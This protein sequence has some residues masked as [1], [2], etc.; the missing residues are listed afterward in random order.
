[1][2]K[3]PETVRQQTNRFVSVSDATLNACVQF[4]QEYPGIVPEHQ[5]IEKLMTLDFIYPLLDGTFNEGKILEVGCGSGLQSAVLT[6]LGDVAATELQDTVGWLGTTIDNTRQ[7]VFEALARNPIDF[8]FN[9][10]LSFPFDDGKFDMVFHNSVI[11]HVPSVELFN[12]ETGRV[13]KTGGIC[14][15]VTGTPMLCRLRF[16]RRYLLMFPLIFAHA[17][18]AALFNGT[19]VLEKLFTRTQS[20]HFARLDQRL[21]QILADHFAVEKTA[22]TLKTSTL[23]DM[24]PRLRH[25]IRDPFYNRIVIERLAAD[26]D[27]SPQALLLQL[28]SHFKSRWNIFLFRMTVPTHGQHTKNS[29]TETREWRVENWKQMFVD[30]G[31]DV[32]AVRGYRYQ[33]IFEPTLSKRLNSWLAYKALPLVRA[34]SRRLPVWFSSEF[35]LVATKR[36]SSAASQ[37]HQQVKEH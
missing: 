18:L 13:L 24:Y 10:G 22:S 37:Q 1:M 7:R 34:M 3:I 17:M 27:V 15:C 19:L 32:T 36:D 4:S 11:E 20:W 16:F 28:I 12:Q 2:T 6:N 14:I 8:R 35:I 9:D 5:I 25:F 21:Q 29:R 23:R 31:F 33:Q 26:H 30:A